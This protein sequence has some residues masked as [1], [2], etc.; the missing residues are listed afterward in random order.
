[1]PAVLHDLQ[2]PFA[3]LAAEEPIRRIGDGILR[4]TAADDHR[5]PHCE[6]RHE[7]AW[8]SEQRAKNQQD[9]GEEPNH[10]ARH[11]QDHRHP[12]EVRWAVGAR[13]G[14]QT[15]VEAHRHQ[16]VVERAHCKAGGG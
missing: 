5:E 1:M 13:A 7:K 9:D 8:Q 15:R 11:G 14:R 6:R 10:E 12:V 3:R 16:Q 4:H 2:P